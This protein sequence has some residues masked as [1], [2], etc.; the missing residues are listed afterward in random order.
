MIMTALG[1]EGQLGGW[2][3]CGGREGGE[4]W[5]VPMSQLVSSRLGGSWG[6]CEDGR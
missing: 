6:G 4:W 1:E 2:E 5:G 3:V